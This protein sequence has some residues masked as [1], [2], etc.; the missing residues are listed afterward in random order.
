[1]I[2]VERVAPGNH[3]PQIKTWAK[4]SE[5]WAEETLRIKTET[6]MIAVAIKVF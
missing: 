3:T 4:V 5:T 6:K 2:K 1:M